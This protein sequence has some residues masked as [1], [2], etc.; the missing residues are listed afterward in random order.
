[1]DRETWKK[2]ISISIGEYKKLVENETKIKTAI[3]FCKGEN[4]VDA[5]L[6]LK[7]FDAEV[8]ENE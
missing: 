1:M 2:N 8:E 3:R 7:I 6:L 4:F 5:K